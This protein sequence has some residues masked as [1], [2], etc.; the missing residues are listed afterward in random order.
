MTT[1]H[2]PSLA[3]VAGVL[4]LGEKELDLLLWNYLGRS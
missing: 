3:D 1:L 4:G 2:S